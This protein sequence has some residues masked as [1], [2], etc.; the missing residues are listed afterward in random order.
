MGAVLLGYNWAFYLR[1]D[2]ISMSGF[3]HTERNVYLLAVLLLALSFLIELVAF[4][5]HYI[6]DKLS[7]EDLS[8][9]SFILP[10]NEQFKRS[11]VVLDTQNSEFIVDKVNE[12]IANV[13][14]E[15]ISNIPR[16]VALKLYAKLDNGPWMLIGTSKINPA[17]SEQNR[18]LIHFNQDNKETYSELKIVLESNSDFALALSAIAVNVPERL[19]ISFVRIA[20]I[21]IV[22]LACWCIKRYTLYELY[23]D[24]HKRSHKRANLA[25]ML[26]ALLI[27]TFFLWG[28]YPK[29]TLPWGFDFF[30]EGSYFINTHEQAL[31]YKVPQTV[32]ENNTSGVYE[33]ML[34]SW[35]KGQNHLNLYVD[36]QLERLNDPYDPSERMVKKVRFTLD[37]AYYQG[38]YYSSFGLAPLIMVYIPV[39]ALTGMTLAPA[40]T[41]YLLSLMAIFSILW[42]YR[43]LVRALV[44]R[45]NLL[46]Y[47][48]V[49]I[50]ALCSSLIFFIFVGLS[51]YYLPF[52]AALTWF[53]LY[54][55]SIARLFVSARSLKALSHKKRVFSYKL[56]LTD[57]TYLLLAGISLPM[58]VCSRPIL[59]FLALALSLPLLVVLIKEHYFLPQETGLLKKQ[60]GQ[61][62]LTTKLLRDS[63]WGLVPLVCGMSLIM[64][65]NYLRFNSVWEFGDSYVLSGDNSALKTLVFN[66]SYVRDVLYYYF[67]EPLTYVKDF[68]FVFANT[69]VYEDH[70]TIL[71]TPDRVA[72]FSL[73]IF[74]AL[75][76]A[77][78][79]Y[80]TFNQTWHLRLSAFKVATLS[81][82]VCLLVLAY[83]MYCKSG[84]VSRY[85]SD[86]AIGASYLVVVLLLL[87]V[88]HNNIGA[89]A[90]SLFIV[91]K[92]MVIS[93]LLPFCYGSEQS[94]NLGAIFNEI[95]PSLMI[96]C[97]RIF[98]PWG[99]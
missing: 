84:A 82:M 23:F 69:N 47:F 42:A 79:S 17:D 66:W 98:T 3:K 51:Y 20:F 39:Y 94:L 91:I 93:L 10:Y 65:Y 81:T 85:T 54:I 1:W 46:L 24:E 75:C 15:T 83:V 72:L 43:S 32:K 19:E 45:A 78:R 49:Q 8:Y 33:Q 5:H 74:W 56:T 44:V 48:L 99:Q 90:L 61:R 73:P 25:L 36:P 6:K 11:V 50:S 88:Q 34:S 64:Y 31:L 96:D 14:L 58:L 9:K 97:Y 12:R 35:L 92:S 71:A 4:N 16:V 22:F 57:K 80:S 68:P 29:N 62:L 18:A 13:A 77:V 37:R 38:K 76:L 28:T 41:M 26:V 40:L 60:W 27:S 30:G 70:G 52:M 59:L 21:F 7:S 87:H 63:L 89:Y 2:L 67:C 55:G 95:N 86:L 53:S